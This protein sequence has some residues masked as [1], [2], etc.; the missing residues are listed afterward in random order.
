MFLALGVGSYI[1]VLNENG[2][3]SIS[4]IPMVNQFFYYF[5]QFPTKTIEQQSTG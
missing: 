1:E 2:T 5:K 4:N 3:G